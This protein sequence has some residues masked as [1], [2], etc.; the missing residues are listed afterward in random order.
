MWCDREMK[1]KFK[2]SFTFVEF[3]LKL[4]HDKQIVDVG[5]NQE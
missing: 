3:R 2:K 5:L 4:K 1:K